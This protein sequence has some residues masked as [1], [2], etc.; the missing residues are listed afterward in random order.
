[1]NLLIKNMTFLLQMRGQKIINHQEKGNA[2]KIN[3]STEM[4]LL[5]QDP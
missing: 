4:L 1:M 2:E 3:G 5:Y